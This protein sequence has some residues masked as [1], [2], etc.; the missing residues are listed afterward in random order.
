MPQLVEQRA[1][2]LER[3]QGGL[4]AGRAREVAHVG[5]D[6]TDRLAVAD[7]APAHPAAPRAAALAGPRVVV[8]VEDREVRPVGVLHLPRL[9]L[10]VIDGEIGPRREGDAVQLVR[11]VERPLLHPV[12]L[13]VGAKLLVVEVVLRLP[14]L[15]RVVPP[16]ARRQRERAP[17][18]L[19]LVLE[20]GRLLQ[21]HL[22][23][24]RPELVQQAVNPGGVLRHVL[25]EH[26]V[27]V[28]LVAEEVGALHPQGRDARDD[29]LVVV[30]VAVVA[31]CQVGIEDLAPLLAVVRVLQERPDAGRLEGVDPLARHPGSLRGIR[32]HRQH[33]RRKTREVLLARDRQPVVVRVVQQVVAELH[34]QHRQLGVHLP[35]LVL[36]RRVEGGA[37]ADVPLVGVL[38]Q[39]L[40]D[41][42]EP[43]RGASFVDGLH[44]PE[45]P[46]VQP[47]LVAQRRQQR[48]HLAVDRLQ[49]RAGLG[50]LQGAEHAVDATEQLPGALEGL[51]RVGEGRSLGVVRD[52]FD[53]LPVLGNRHF[54]GREEVIGLDLLE[55]GNLERGLPLLQQRV[56]GGR[57]LLGPR[58]G[59]A[60]HDEEAEQG[61]T[62]GHGLAFN[63]NRCQ[64]LVHA[65]RGKGRAGARGGDGDAH[66]RRGHPPEAGEPLVAD[67]GALG[68]RA[69]RAVHLGLGAPRLHA[70]AERDG[71][72]E[73]DALERDGCLPRQLDAP[74]GDAIVGGPVGRRVAVVDTRRGED[75][76]AAALGGGRRRGLAGQVPLEGRLARAAESDQPRG[77][78]FGDEAAPVGRD[79]EEQV[80]AAPHRAVVDLHQLRDALHLLVLLRVVEPP[81]PDRDVHLGRHVVGG[82]D[83][84][85]RQVPG[86]PRI[87]R[88]GGRSVEAVPG[89]LECDPLLV[90]D[91]A[92][93]GPG[94][95]EHHRARPQLA[96]DAPGV[97]PVVVAAVVDAPRLPRP[98]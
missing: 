90:A 2:L 48:R 8:G 97:R 39:P 53:L 72:L 26:E 6:G 11:D 33:R 46:L 44:A 31:A 93:V 35:E 75:S 36:L 98:P 43:R 45:Q 3:E 54:E 69:P 9:H 79:V 5:G 27:G 60:E 4:V 23:R 29:R 83:P 58:R 18:G 37:R 56:V 88:V 32:T 96:H 49:P 41:R 14:H 10:G 28:A 78:D 12:E 64:S 59:G 94:V 42:R 16:V 74:R 30:L 1:D 13:E 61:E 19:D 25:L 21:R 22:A 24:R 76:R 80:R 66:S 55:R 65:N 57:G 68:D 63:E 73:D 40:L 62:S 38:D 67:R 70:L 81:G 71:L 52:R 85:P 87:A 92:D 91:P 51:H 86:V 50:P 47:D 95:A 17:F 84:A 15:F 82:V 7:P 89:G 77:I 20:N 34:A